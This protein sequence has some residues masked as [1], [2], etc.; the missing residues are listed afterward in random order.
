MSYDPSSANTVIYGGYNS[1]VITLTYKFSTFNANYQIDF[2]SAVGACSVSSNAII[3]NHGRSFA[4]S[5]ISTSTQ[6]ATN[7][8]NIFSWGF[9]DHGSNS[10]Q[11][12]NYWGNADDIAAGIVKTTARIATDD[13]V[14]QRGQTNV[15]SLNQIGGFFI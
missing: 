2:D 3:P 10:W 6:T 11:S 15:S 9:S 8:Y 13:I 7:N 1:S 12:R 5:D 4:M 14:Q